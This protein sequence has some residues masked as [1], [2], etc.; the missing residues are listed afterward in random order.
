MFYRRKILLALLEAFGGILTKTDCQKLVFLFCVRRGKNYYDFFPHKYGN[1]S[2]LL[3]QDRE[4]LIDLGYLVKQNDFELKEAQA[5]L[6]EQIQDGREWIANTT[7]PG[8]GDASIFI[9]VDW[10]TSFGE[11]KK[12]FSFEQKFPK[13]H[14]V[15]CSLN[16]DHS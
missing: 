14:A 3:H 11:V 10:T 1:F 12:A 9:F 5:Y 4:R 6:E 7:T 8:I 2:F 15:S 16:P 13:S